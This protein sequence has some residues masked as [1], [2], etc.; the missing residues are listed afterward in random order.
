MIRRLL[1]SSLAAP[2]AIVVFIL[3]ANFVYISGITNPNPLN[4][5]SGLSNSIQNGFIRGENDID[6]NDGFG[7]QAL[8]KQ[9]MEDIFHG[10]LPWWNTNEQVGAPLAGEMQSAAFFPPTVLLMLSNG[11]T[12]FHILLEIIAGLST[13]YLLKRLGLRELSSVVGATVF[14]LSAVFVWFWS[15]NTNPV[16]FLP[17]LILGIE[18]AYSR[19]ALKKKGGWFI[20]TAALALSIYAGFPEAT[21][22]DGAL[23]A[24]WAIVRLF[25]TNPAVRAAYIKKILAGAISAVLIAAPLIVAFLDY[26]PYADVGPH[27]GG[28]TASLH[29]IGL[30]A[31]FMPYIYGS[32]FGLNSYDPTGGLTYWWSNVGGYITILMVFIAAIGLI[33]VKAKSSLRPIKIMLAIWTLII[34]LR[35][36]GFPGTTLLAK[37]PGLGETAIYRYS[38]PTLSLAVAILMA[39]G[40]EYIISNKNLQNKLNL[41]KI[42]WLAGAAIVLLLAV[43]PE[44]L[45]QRSHMLGAHHQTLWFAASYLWA[46]L[47]IAVALLLIILIAKKKLTNRVGTYALVALI[48]ADTM[49]M[50]VIPQLS[51]PQSAT[52]NTQPVTYL[53]QNLGN[54]RFYSLGPIMPNYSSYFNIASIDTNNLPIAKNWASYITKDLDKNANPVVFVGENANSLVPANETVLQAFLQNIKNYEYI[55]TKYLVTTNGALSTT[56]ASAAGLKLVHQDTTASIYALPD[57]APYFQVVQGD[58]NFQVQSRTSIVTNCTKPSVILRRELFMPGW[59]A[60]V[61]GQTVNAAA[62]GPLFESYKIPAGN[63]KVTFSYVPKHT[64]LAFLGLLVGIIMVAVVYVPLYHE[65]RKGDAVPKS[66]KK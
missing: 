14:A 46:I 1:K 65:K 13:Y 42:Y 33:G 50:F 54:Y 58:C 34:T 11:M 22:L 61:D 52:I 10:K 26:L 49:L 12:C 27:S 2:L 3:I 32:I 25:Q 63:H 59:T 23:A 17:L 38:Q 39:F 16:A 9:S 29:A 57:P 28:I 15:A 21:F 41:K 66:K 53:Q 19:A 36:Y 64:S 45:I 44:A 8:G 30:P 31:L 24:V 56:E 20:I 60:N 18:I 4:T 51:A 48:L 62:Y 6:P 40:L 7:V 35:I 43:L 55:G 47:S 37:I 5:R